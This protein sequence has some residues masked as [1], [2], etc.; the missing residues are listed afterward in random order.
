MTHCFSYGD[1][2]L[3]RFSF[4]PEVTILVYSGKGI[5]FYQISGDGGNVAC[6][7]P[8]LCFQIFVPV[9]CG[10]AITVNH[11]KETFFCWDTQILFEDHFEIVFIPLVIHIPQHENS[12]LRYFHYDYV[13][14]HM[15][16]YVLCF[17]QCVLAFCLFVQQ[18]HAT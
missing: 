6:T 3:N 10:N 1:L 8:Y 7:S 12:H 4:M 2:T 5:V 16:S 15:L 18:L 17:I 13:A 14:V 11:M 9:S